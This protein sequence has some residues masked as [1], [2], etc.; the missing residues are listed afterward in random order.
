VEL[1][2]AVLHQRPPAETGVD[3]VNVLQLVADVRRDGP[4]EADVGVRNVILVRSGRGIFRSVFVSGLL[5]IDVVEETRP[6][7]RIDPDEARVFMWFE[8]LDPTMTFEFAKQTVIEHYAKS[9][10]VMMPSDFNLSWKNEYR[11]ILQKELDE[12]LK[13][14]S[15][16]SIPI[17]QLLKQVIH[18]FS[19]HRCHLFFV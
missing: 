14:E 4:E 10:T 6:A 2:L 5:G 18:A 3:D 9:K 12:R 16:N 19:S 7:D 17:P 13:L 15:Q 11:R 1:P 8:V